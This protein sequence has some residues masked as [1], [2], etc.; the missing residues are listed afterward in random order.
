[1]TGFPRDTAER[2]PANL[3]PLINYYASA[4]KTGS[5]PSITSDQLFLWTRPH[6]KNANPSSPTLSKPSNWQYTDDNLYVVV[7]LTQ[8]AKV[9]IYSGTNKASWNAPA[10]LNKFSVP[11]LPGVVGATIERGG[12][13]VKSY[14]SSGVFSYTA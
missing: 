12:V 10:G 11:S 7:L 5:Y 9:T 4:F 1:M 14:D 2:H 8:S 3:H 13:V 6:S